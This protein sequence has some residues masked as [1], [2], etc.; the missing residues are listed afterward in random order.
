[1]L[2]Q[3]FCVKFWIKNFIWAHFVGKPSQI[4]RAQTLLKVNLQSLTNVVQR[5]FIG[6]LPGYL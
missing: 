2:D 5:S 4:T 1:M 3:K 6:F